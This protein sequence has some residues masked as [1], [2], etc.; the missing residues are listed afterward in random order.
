MIVR[1]KFCLF[2]LRNR[3]EV[4][5]LKDKPIFASQ[6]SRMSHLWNKDE[7]F[8]SGSSRQFLAIIQ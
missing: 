2:L 4:I 1:K 8:N 7:V 6:V 5:C 3:T